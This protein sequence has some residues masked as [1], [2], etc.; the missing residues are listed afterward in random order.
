LP[1]SGRNTTPA[2]SKAAQR[3]QGETNAA[4][5]AQIDRAAAQINPTVAATGRA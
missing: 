2:A 4:L 5:R 1:F 3:G